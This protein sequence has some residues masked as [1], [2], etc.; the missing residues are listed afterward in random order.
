MDAIPLQSPQIILTDPAEVELALTHRADLAGALAETLE[1]FEQFCAA[2]PDLPVGL[3]LDCPALEPDRTGSWTEEY[4]MRCKKAFAP[5]LKTK[6]SFWYLR[7][8]VDFGALRAAVL[9]VT[10]CS[11]RSIVAALPMAEGERLTDNTDCVAAVGV[12]Q[13]IGVSTVV[14]TGE[15][16]EDLQEALERLAPYARISIGVRCPLAWAQEGILLPNTEL[17]LP[18]PGERAADLIGM[19]SEVCLS[20]MEREYLEEYI[21]APDGRDA[22]FIDPT[23]DISDEIPCETHLSER[24]IALE[25]EEA[26]AFKLVLEEE[27]DLV[28]LE[29]EMYMISRPICLCAEDPALLERALRIYCGLALYDGTWELEEEILSFFE[30]KYGLIRL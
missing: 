10:D 15:N 16:R 22:H 23:T 29:E 6:A 4:I 24:L 12:L 5:R 25:D 13:R 2:V 28:T 18:V 7:G 11:G 26:A 3:I 21:L 17:L 1:D 14:L 8:A 19:R 20:Q 30:A 9:A 27:G